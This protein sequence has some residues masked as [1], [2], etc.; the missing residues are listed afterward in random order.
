MSRKIR[1]TRGQQAMKEAEN[2]ANDEASAC[3]EFNPTNL[4]DVFR[5]VWFRRVQM[6][7]LSE[8]KWSLYNI[9]CV[10]KGSFC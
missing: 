1:Q 3:S 8:H 7:P 2:K 5:P 4:S 6:N 9:S 10:R